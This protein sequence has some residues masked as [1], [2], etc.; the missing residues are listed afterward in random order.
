V[1]YKCIELKGTRCRRKG[2]HTEPCL[3][4][5]LTLKEGYDKIRKVEKESPAMT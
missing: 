2:S 4:I 5:Q 1:I 3:Y